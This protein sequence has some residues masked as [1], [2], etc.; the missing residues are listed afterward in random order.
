MEANNPSP[1]SAAAKRKQ[2][3]LGRIAE[4]SYE[5]I[6][7]MKVENRRALEVRRP[8]YPLEG[9]GKQLDVSRKWHLSGAPNPVNQVKRHWLD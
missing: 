3:Q 1:K 5:P 4:K 2:R 6:V 7:P 8:R 9:R